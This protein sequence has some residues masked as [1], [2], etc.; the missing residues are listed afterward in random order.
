[1]FEQWR[2][3]AFSEGPLTSLAVALTFLVAAVIFE[4][5]TRRD[6]RRYFSRN[7]RTDALYML[8]YLGGVY[9]VLVSQPLVSTL[10]RL[11]QRYAGGLHLGLL[12]QPLLPPGLRVVLGIL[13]VDLAG[14]WLHRWMHSSPTLWAFHSIHHSQQRLTLLTNFRAHIGDAAVQTAVIFVVGIVLSPPPA[15]WA[16]VGVLYI[17]IALL[18]HSSFTWSYGP[19]DRLIVSPRHHS[20]HHSSDPRHYGTNLGMTFS[21]W[22]Y[23]F[24]TVTRDAQ[25]PRAFGVP[26]LTVPE[27]FVGQLAFPFQHLGRRWRHRI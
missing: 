2:A 4:V 27:S 19:L 1:L 3:S 12:E 10:R 9:G 18:A 25:P 24:G 16:V 17:V 26:G 14:Y 6:P 7:A 5:A 8:F 15:P 22:D 13:L 20:F 23:L 21:L 11:T